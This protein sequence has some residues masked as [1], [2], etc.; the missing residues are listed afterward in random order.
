M[1]LP[2]GQIMGRYNL[3]LVHFLVALGVV[4]PLSCFLVLVSTN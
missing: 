2:E 1:I 4:T 3:V